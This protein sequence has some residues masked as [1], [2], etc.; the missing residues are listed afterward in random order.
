MNEVYRPVDIYYG[1]FLQKTLD[2]KD[3]FKNF[4]WDARWLK[5]LSVF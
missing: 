1:S 3:R 2:P 4:M 5:E